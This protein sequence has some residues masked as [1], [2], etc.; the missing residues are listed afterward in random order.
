ML[1]F[2]GK[3]IDDVLFAFTN[4]LTYK[5]NKIGAS[6]VRMANTFVFFFV[7]SKMLSSNNITTILIISIASGLGRYLSFYVDKLLTKDSNWLLIV[8][9]KGDKKDLQPSIDELRNM[10]IDV[11]SFKT[12][13]EDD[14]SSLSLKILSHDRQTTKIV[15]GLLPSGVNINVVELKEY[16]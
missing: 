2:V 13:H 6:I 16:I 8:N 10:N 7:V 3:F 14:N 9:Y 11:F 5:E 4:I 1:G 12:Y 15:K